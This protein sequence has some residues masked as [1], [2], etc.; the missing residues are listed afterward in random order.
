MDASVD[1]PLLQSLKKHWGQGIISAAQV[2]E[3]AWGASKQGAVG[4]SSPAAAG[5]SGKHAQN[6]HRSLIAL[7]GRPKGSPEISWYEVP[8]A[9]GTRMHPF[10]LPH[11][12]FSSLYSDL[13]E[14]FASA[15]QGSDEAA[16]M[17]FW[18]LM[19][20]TDF[21]QQHPHMHHQHLGKTIPLG[22]Y[23]DAG[24]FSHQES[25]YIF[26]WNSLLGVGQTKAKRFFG[27]LY[28]EERSDR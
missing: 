25:L 16:C 12:F 2:Q 15:V 7:F 6:I 9:K 20:G 19:A 18:T 14:Q 3:Y 11:K 1:L 23:G 26:T 10:M 24:K 13:P 17:A 5:S 8:T 21:F 28:S 27:Y 4:M 22:L